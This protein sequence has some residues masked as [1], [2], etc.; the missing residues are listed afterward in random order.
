M[1]TLLVSELVS[2]AVIH[3]DAPDASDILLEAHLLDE[4]A[5]RVE[6]VDQGSGFTSLPRDPTQQEGGFGLFL[7]ERQSSRWGVDERGGT[8][9]WFELTR[10]GR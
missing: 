4:G 5:V 10:D 7:V 3:S 2:N 9:V 6:V 1:V 8:R